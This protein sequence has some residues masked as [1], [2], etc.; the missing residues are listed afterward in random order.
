[1]TKRR[2]LELSTLA[3]SIGISRLRQE[4]DPI[5]KGLHIWRLLEN[6]IEDGGGRKKVSP[7][8]LSMGIASLSC[9]EVSQ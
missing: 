6:E 2:T 7:F 4:S 3:A 1:M 8:F 5:V 9:H